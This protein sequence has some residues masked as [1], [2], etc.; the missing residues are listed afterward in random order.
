MTE[1][2]LPLLHIGGDGAVNVEWEIENILPSELPFTTELCAF[3]VV[4]G[5][6][7]TPDHPGS[8]SGNMQNIEARRIYNAYADKMATRL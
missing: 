2:L 5:E 8:T 7:L 4:G 6:C 3:F 1:K